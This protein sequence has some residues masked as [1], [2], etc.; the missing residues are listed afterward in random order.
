V[1]SATT[2]RKQGGDLKIVNPSGVVQK[3]LSVTRVDTVIDVK[4]DEAGAL[5]SFSKA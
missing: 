2:L 5:Q 3:L 1:G 4:P